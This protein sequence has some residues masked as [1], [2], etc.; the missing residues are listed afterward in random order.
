MLELL[1]RHLVFTESEVAARLLHGWDRWRGRLVKVM[2][3]DY[4]RALAV[5]RRE[6]AAAP[7]LEAAHG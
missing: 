2:P 7:A 4:K 1:R 3:R 5:L 6:S